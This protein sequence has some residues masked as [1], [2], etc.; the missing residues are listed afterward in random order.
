VS[1]AIQA[2]NLVLPSGTAKIGDQELLVRLN[3]S[4]DDREIASLPV[5]SVNGATVTI[6]DVARCATA[7]RRR[8]ASSA[9]TVGGAS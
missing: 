3:S 6:G 2:Q 4:P 5:K 7:S 8:R 1:N 9:P